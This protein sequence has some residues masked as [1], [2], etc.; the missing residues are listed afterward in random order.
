MVWYAWGTIINIVDLFSPSR[1]VLGVTEMTVNKKDL[2]EVEIL[3]WFIT[4]AGF[5]M[6][7]SEQQEGHG[8][9]VE[10]VL[11]G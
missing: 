9:L 8:R 5:T 6:T 2:T 11:N 3:T 4:P 1:F 7:G 10:A